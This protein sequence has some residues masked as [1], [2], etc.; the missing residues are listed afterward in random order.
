MSIV[1]NK[2]QIIF[3]SKLYLRQHYM[4]GKIELQ[5]LL[6]DKGSGFW[7]RV[8]RPDPQHWF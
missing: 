5:G 1:Y 6:V 2:D 7:I 4:I 3:C 8:K